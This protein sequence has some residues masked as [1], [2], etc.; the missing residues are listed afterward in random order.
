MHRSPGLVD[1]VKRAKDWSFPTR[2]TL[3]KSTSD[4]TR[5][6]D[7]DDAF[8]FVDHEPPPP[9]LLEDFEPHQILGDKKIKTVKMGAKSN[10]FDYTNRSSTGSKLGQIVGHALEKEAVKLQKAADK[11]AEKLRKQSGGSSTT[12]C[13]DVVHLH[14]VDLQAPDKDLG[15][16]GL[17]ALADGL[18]TA[19]RSGTRLAIEDLNLSGNTLTTASLQRLA[20]IIKLARHDLKTLNLSNNKIK[21]DTNEEAEQW[22]EFMQSFRECF[23]LRRMDLRNNEDLGSRAMEILARVHTREH[24]ID[25][26]TPNWCDS[27]LSLLSDHDPEGLNEVAPELEQDDREHG[28]LTIGQLLKNRRGLRSIPYIELNNIGLTDSGALWLSYVVQDHYYPTQLIDGLNATAAETAI[29]AYQQDNGIAGVSWDASAAGPAKDARALLR[30]TEA[31]RY[32]SMLEEHS[33]YAD[34]LLEDDEFAEGQ[35]NGSRGKRSLERRL[36][37]CRR[38]QQ[39]RQYEVDTH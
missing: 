9:L 23:R 30:K 16:E 22:E 27:V 29:S 21:V 10:K 8:E 15:D 20:P 19:L 31:V 37:K 6:D 1:I 17:R 2:C 36:S 39:D 26:I 4:H 28:R 32:R 25:P 33:V 3:P 35:D 5:H 11:E 13:D 38:P 7:L 18:E 12:T 24:K 14:V 34:S